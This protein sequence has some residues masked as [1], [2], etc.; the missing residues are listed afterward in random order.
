MTENVSPKRAEVVT[1]IGL[2]LQFVFS[3]VVLVL[4]FLNGSAANK[5]EAW[6]FLAGVAFWGIVFAHLRQR[7]LA[8]E[9]QLE[10]EELETSRKEATAE[11]KPLFEGDELE[12]YSARGRLRTMEK[13]AIPIISVIISGGLIYL[14]VYVFT[15]LWGQTQFPSIKLSGAAPISFILLS[16]ITF[17]TFLYAKYAAGM[18]AVKEWRL[19]RAGATY[20]M[21]NAVI[22]FA[23]LISIVA[24]YLFDWQKLDKIVAYVVP[25]VVMLLG[26]EIILNV[27]LLYDSAGGRPHFPVE[28]LFL[29]KWS[30]FAASHYFPETDHF[31]PLSV[32]SC[33][34]RLATLTASAASSP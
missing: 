17:V 2:V 23:T 15:S 24:A 33:I 34:K 5:A 28:F 19:L 7:R 14:A 26:L 22:L 30:F 27:I 20:M 11:G 9:E 4:G 13:W 1:L 6:H 32:F 21:S 29:Y 18:A 31:A 16:I 25:A 12:S 3:A 10:C 8:A